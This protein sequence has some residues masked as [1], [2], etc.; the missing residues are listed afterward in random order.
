MLIKQMREI[1][2]TGTL[3]RLFPPERKDETTMAAPVGRDVG[4]RLEA[5]RDAVVDRLSVVVL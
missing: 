4:D 1:R 5:V 2:R 3:P